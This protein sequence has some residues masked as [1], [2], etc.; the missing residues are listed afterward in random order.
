MLNVQVKLVADDRHSTVTEFSVFT[1]HVKR[2]SRKLR[3]SLGLSPMSHI[4]KRFAHLLC[5]RMQFNCVQSNS[6]SLLVTVN[7][8]SCQ[9][10]TTH[11]LFPLICS[12]E[13]NFLW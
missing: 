2:W 9:T 3:V 12:S 11:A 13:M 1:R 4:L 10:P 5:N 7:A 6:Y 8:S